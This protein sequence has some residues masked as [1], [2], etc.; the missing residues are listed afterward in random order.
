MISAI[1]ENL[2]NAKSDPQSRDLKV[3]EST[4][5]LIQVV[6]RL[7]QWEKAEL[8]AYQSPLWWTVTTADGEIYLWFRNLE[9]ASCLVNLWAFRI[10]CLT[11]VIQL[12]RESPSLLLQAISIDGKS[13]DGV[14][15]TGEIIQLSTQI[16]QSMEFWTQGKLGIYGAASAAMPLQTA[17]QALGGMGSD[18]EA[19]SRSYSKTVERIVEKRG[20]KGCL[21]RGI[22]M[23][24]K[25]N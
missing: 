16:I 5:K 12:R 11:N 8:S 23:E 1:F 15:V 22:A 24:S 18:S 2:D 3:L 14:E 9:V 6:N 13:I 17:I 10:I 4:S 19:G 20:F 25:W 21:V 7:E